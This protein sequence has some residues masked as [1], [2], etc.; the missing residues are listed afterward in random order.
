MLLLVGNILKLVVQISFQGRCTVSVVFVLVRPL[1]LLN[2]G[3]SFQG[4][5]VISLVTP[6]VP[7]HLGLLVVPETG[8]HLVHFAV[9]PL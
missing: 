1:L 3:L 6:F 7:Q 4:T 2:L 9:G 8:L 5:A